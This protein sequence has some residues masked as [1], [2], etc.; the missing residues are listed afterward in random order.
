MNKTKKSIYKVPEKSANIASKASST[1]SNFFSGL[2][3]GFSS[4]GVWFD[5]PA[6]VAAFFLGILKS[7]PVVGFFFPTCLSSSSSVSSVLMGGDDL[8]FLKMK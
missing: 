7:L 4:D 8:R 1:C 6:G 3:N 5:D 2:A